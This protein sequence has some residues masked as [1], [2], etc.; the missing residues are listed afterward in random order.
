MKR[1]ERLKVLEERVTALEARELEKC[2]SISLTMQPE[3]L[4]RLRC[5]K[6]ERIYT[7]TQFTAHVNCLDCKVPLERV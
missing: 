2:P 7:E 5:P 1:E 6:C 4:Y 3:V